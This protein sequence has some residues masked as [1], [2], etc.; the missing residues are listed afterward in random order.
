MARQEPQSPSPAAIIIGKLLGD[1]LLSSAL[2][3]LVLASW[4]LAQHDVERVRREAGEKWHL[5]AGVHQLQAGREAG[6]QASVCSQGT[7][8][9]EEGEAGAGCRVRAPPGFTPGLELP[10][11]PRMNHPSEK[12]GPTMAGLGF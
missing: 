4:V 3:L 8:E 2:V 1:G 10:G 5:P 12:G 7:Q 9:Q 6:R 11:L